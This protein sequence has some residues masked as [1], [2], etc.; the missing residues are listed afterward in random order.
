MAQKKQQYR[1][2]FKHGQ[3]AYMRGVS[4]QDVRKKVGELLED[5]IE[6]VEEMRG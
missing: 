4:E 5:H 6:R 3:T 2:H 1:I